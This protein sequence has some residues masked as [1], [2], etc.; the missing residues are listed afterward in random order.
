MSD[1]SMNPLELFVRYGHS[2]SHIQKDILKKITG[3]E[4]LKI[5]RM[6]FGGLAPDESFL[7]KAFPVAFEWLETIAEGQPLDEDIIDGYFLFYHNR[8]IHESQGNYRNVPKTLR[9][10]CLARVAKVKEK[11]MHDEVP[12]YRCED[13]GRIL[14]SVGRVVPDAMVG[15]W[16][17]THQGLAI[18]KISLERLN[19]LA[20]LYAKTPGYEAIARSL[21]LRGI[22]K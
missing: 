2:C 3:E 19:H 1:E 5:E 9:E 18:R 16:I 20:G 15:D 10:F 17:I 8:R 22:P 21:E 13:E 7:R 11:I 14:N 12:L 4:H 6:C